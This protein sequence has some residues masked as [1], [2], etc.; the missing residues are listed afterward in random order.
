MEKKLPSYLGAVSTVPRQ[1][2]TGCN[3]VPVPGER[4]T[5]PAVAAVLLS[6]FIAACAGGTQGPEVKAPAAAGSEDG[7]DG[8]TTSG[9]EAT[10]P[11]E[12][13]IRGTVV[14]YHGK[15]LA[16]AE[17]HLS[18]SGATKDEVQS[19]AVAPDG[20]FTVKGAP[21]GIIRLH[22][23]AIDS[24]DYL[25]PLVVDGS[26]VELDVKLGTYALSDDLSKVAVLTEGMKQF[27]EAIP[28]AAQA[29]G[30]YAVEIDAPEGEVAYELVN[31]TTSNSIN[32]TMGTEYR[33]DDGGN[34]YSVV[35]ANATKVK[36][37]FDPKKLPPSARP[38]E[39]RFRDPNSMTA[40]I[41]AISKRM[42]DRRRKFMARARALMEQSKGPP[43][44]TKLYDWKE[45]TADRKAVVAMLESA[46]EEI[47]KQALLIEYFAIGNP[48]KKDGEKPTVSPEHQALAKRVFAEI[49]ADSPLWGLDGNALLAAARDLGDTEA[50]TAYLHRVVDTHADKQIASSTLLSLLF[51]AKGENRDSDVRRYYHTMVTRFPDTAAAR[52][53]KRVSPH[54]KIRA[55]ATMPDFDFAALGRPDVHY[56]PDDFRGKVYLV[57]FWATWC[58]PCIAQMPKLHEVYE[59]HKGSGFTILSVAVHDSEK[60]V[61]RFQGGTWTMPWNNAFLSSD[62]SQEIEELF[63]VYGIPSAILVDR[64]GR[65]AAVNEDALGDNLGPLVEKLV[66]PKK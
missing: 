24:V 6:V 2:A 62:A 34:Y 4:R 46:T 50:Q 60:A 39:L 52:S 32:G 56:K 63:E 11:T 48:P 30:T 22:F 10:A 44:M 13:L 51:H 12:T 41:A 35:K 65:I 7:V 59:K 18:K 21:R 27:S 42:L 64:N 49:P 66:A 23:T 1:A 38:T 14:G 53:A 28:M 20:T 9:A 47:V 33:Y 54:R 40:R 25:L 26:T 29:D 43:D 55:G 61:K 19:S 31:V 15:P 17:V 5:S 37:V 58:K 36:I 8:A 3:R 57:E 45:I 16:K